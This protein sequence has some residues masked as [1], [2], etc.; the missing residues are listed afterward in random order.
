MKRP[1]K[2]MEGVERPIEDHFSSLAYSELEQLKRL[3]SSHEEHSPVTQGLLE[4]IDQQMARSDAVYHSLG[5]FTPLELMRRFFIH[6]T[7]MLCQQDV[8]QDDQRVHIARKHF[9]DVSFGW[10]EDTSIND[11]PM[12]RRGTWSYPTRVQMHFYVSPEFADNTGASYD[13]ERYLMMELDG[14]RTE[15]MIPWCFQG[16]D[17]NVGG[18][19]QVTWTGEHW[20]DHQGYWYD[21]V[22]IEAETM[23][24]G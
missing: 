5:V 16:T 14:G 13:Q 8:G 19:L 6:T 15:S 9:N 11:G 21:Q 22:R 18:H 10:E 12:R 17:G 7:C 20:E 1:K 2:F 24:N 23:N 3:L 4:R